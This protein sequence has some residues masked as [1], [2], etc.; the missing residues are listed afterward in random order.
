MKVVGGGQFPHSSHHDAVPKHRPKKHLRW[1]LGKG[2]FFLW[3]AT[4]TIKMNAPLRRLRAGT[5]RGQGRGARRAVHRKKGRAAAVPGG[6]GSE[7]AALRDDDP[8]QQLVGEHG[9]EALVAEGGGDLPGP[10]W[11]LVR[12]AP[13]PNTPRHEYS[14][15]MRETQHENGTFSTPT[16]HWIQPVWYA[17][18]LD[19]TTAPGGGDTHGPYHRFTW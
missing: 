8:A 1:G 15:K 13:L 4:H 12:P 17:C 2:D 5:H 9:A 7:E 11:V 10:G 3:N 14:P 16:H 6:G 18:R 19:L